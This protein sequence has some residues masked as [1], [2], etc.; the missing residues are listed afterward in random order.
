[1]P[2]RSL[3]TM[4]GLAKEDLFFQRVFVRIPF[5]GRLLLYEHSGYTLEQ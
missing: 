4:S 1:M 3:V 2:M 5:L